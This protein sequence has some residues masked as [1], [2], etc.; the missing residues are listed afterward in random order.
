MDRGLT[1]LNPIRV[2][3]YTHYCAKWGKECVLRLVLP[4]SDGLNASLPMPS[5]PSIPG[6]R[7]PDQITR[8]KAFVVM[9]K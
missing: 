3:L 4:R 5:L 8:H 2:S 1:S 9:V 6:R 7:R